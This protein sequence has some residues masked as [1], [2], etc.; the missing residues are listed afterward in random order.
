MTGWTTFEPVQANDE[1]VPEL[2]ASTVYSRRWV[3]DRGDGLFSVAT[4]K[5]YCKDRWENAGAET[6]QP[7]WSQDDPRERFCL[8]QQIELV[9]CPDPRELGDGGI[10]NE[11][12]CR[13]SDF[14]F[15]TAM[16]DELVEQVM[17]RF[18]AR[19]ITWDGSEIYGRDRSDV[20]DLL[21]EPVT[22]ERW[23]MLLPYEVKRW[24]AAAI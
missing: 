14:S 16:P 19:H 21:I 6:E 11:M 1:A 8:S 5:F 24:I 4:V 7:S 9:V 12:R 10:W 3:L 17:Q 2:Q 22:E 20:V 23:L 18:G 13:T 15:P